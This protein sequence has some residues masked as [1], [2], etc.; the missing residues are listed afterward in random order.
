MAAAADEKKDRRPLSKILEDIEAVLERQEA[1]KDPGAYERKKAREEPLKV[2]AWEDPVLQRGLEWFRTAPTSLRRALDDAKEDKGVALKAWRRE[3][4]EIA[5][6][7]DDEDTLKEYPVEAALS[8]LD[9]RYG[10]PAGAQ[11]AARQAGFDALKKM[12]EDMIP[13]FDEKKRVELLR[14]AL[15]FVGIELLR[16]TPLALI[17]DRD[18]FATKSLDAL[19]DTFFDTL[20]SHIRF[21][22]CSHSET[23]CRKI[24][25]G[26]L[27]KWHSRVTPK[28]RTALHGLLQDDDEPPSSQT[29][30]ADDPTRSLQAILDMATFDDFRLFERVV[31]VIAE[32]A[33]AEVAG[34]TNFWPTLLVDV[35]LHATPT[36]NATKY[37]MAAVR[38]VATASDAVL[39]AGKHDD[40]SFAKL[41][42][43]LARGD[44]ATTTTTTTTTQKQQRPAPAAP[45]VPTTRTHPAGAADLED[46]LDKCWQACK[47][48]D[49]HLTFANPVTD[50]IAPGYSKRVKEPM[51]LGTM[52]SKIGRVYKNIDEFQ[53]DVRRIVENCKKFNGPSS[54]YTTQAQKLWRAF[55]KAK[56]LYFGADLSHPPP[57]PVA[58]MLPKKRPAVE[59][60]APGPRRRD[61]K[62]Q[63]DHD[64]FRI[65]S[66]VVLAEPFA[67]AVALK[68]L[69]ADVEAAVQR[70]QVPRDRKRSRDLTQYLALVTAARTGNDV[71]PAM[72]LLT[73]LPKLAHALAEARRTAHQVDK[74]RKRQD[75]AI[76]TV[77]TA[78]LGDTGLDTAAETMTGS[79]AE[80]FPKKQSKS[81]KIHA[82]FDDVPCEGIVTSRLAA[83]VS[84]KIHRR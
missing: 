60:P 69:W 7:A 51:D 64:M 31:Q 50:L 53:A 78:A 82:F 40:G 19:P 65:V 23:R 75:D 44:Q 74:K 5:D 42:A 49:P 30:I 79:A 33:L 14:G 62:K 38:Q 29:R 45:A 58:P 70:R 37:R 3:A 9:P 24:L 71:T 8:L 52:R 66:R 10:Q 13:K 6:L 4:Q 43:A 16:S 61:E 20:P 80:H 25:F 76:P 17:T 41:R 54:P 68:N 21:R 83:V 26:L 73:D 39:L 55:L 11:A 47:K 32:V 15:P 59:E 57:P 81:A 84:H 63:T 77:L 48:A 12:F 18:V 34:E 56:D 1:E 67:E 2:T 36:V 22:V 35:I 28:L 46:K 27:D 72:D